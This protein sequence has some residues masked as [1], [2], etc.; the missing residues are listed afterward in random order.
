MATQN[1]RYTFNE[2]ALRQ[3]LQSP[4]AGVA[5]DLLR[6]GTRVQTYARREVKVD[7]GRLRSSIV[8]L[9]GTYSGNELVARIGTNVKYARFVHDGTG[10]YGPRH[11]EIRP[12]KVMMFRV[13]GQSNPVFT[14]KSVGQRPSKFLSDAL[15]A[16]LK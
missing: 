9:L 16:A 8:V 15:H 5:R 1:V 14:M 10:I 7:T 11:R 3:L 12:G 13:R 2:R 4:S 6:R